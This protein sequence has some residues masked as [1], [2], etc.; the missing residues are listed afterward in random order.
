MYFTTDLYLSRFR[1]HNFGSE[2]FGGG[3]KEVK[4]EEEELK[5]RQKSEKG[6][7]QINIRW[8]KVGR[9]KRRIKRNKTINITVLSRL[10]ACSVGK[11]TTSQTSVLLYNLG[12]NNGH[13][14]MEIWPKE[15][16]LIAYNLSETRKNRF[17]PVQVNLIMGTGTRNSIYLLMYSC[18]FIQIRNIVKTWTLSPYF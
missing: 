9:K 1:I 13:T 16:K 17:S 8:G 5:Y 10:Q 4:E 6:T 14:A 7:E 3:K 18:C 11:T 15:I 2:S 12:W